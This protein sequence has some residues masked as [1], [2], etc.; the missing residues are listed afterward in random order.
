MG[1]CSGLSGVDVKT[2]TETCVA[3][4]TASRLDAAYLY[5]KKLEGTGLTQSPVRIFYSSLH[6]S[7]MTTF[8][9][10]VGAP[11]TCGV[12]EVLSLA[13]HGKL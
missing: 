3:C 10:D 9:S 12:L 5:V 1:R 7:V 2:Y 8:T 11:N 6:S 13:K 4:T